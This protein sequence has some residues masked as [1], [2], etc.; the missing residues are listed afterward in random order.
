MF[1]RVIFAAI[2]GG[3]LAFGGGYINHE[4][5][6][7]M[8]RHMVQMPDAGPAKE[9]IAKNFPKSGVYVF[10]ML[11]MAEMA[12]MD[13][14]DRDAAMDKFKQEFKAGPGAFVSVAPVGEDFDMMKF[15]G[16]EIGSNVIAA[17]LAA[18]VVALSRPGLGPVVRWFIVVLMGT[19]AWASISASYHIWF[20]FPQPWVLDELYCALIEWGLAGIAIAAI[21]VPKERTPGY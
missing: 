5:L 20:R 2:I 3:A 16:W 17:F 11:P 1:F 21:V 19:F 18:L 8:G 15:F 13:E 12:K 4:I 7:L 6:K 10:P 14:K 9:T